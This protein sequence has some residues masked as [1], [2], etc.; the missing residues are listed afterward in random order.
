MTT[1]ERYKDEI[2]L[3]GLYDKDSVYGGM[4]GEALERLV[5]CHLNENHSGFSHYHLVHLFNQLMTTNLL[6]PLQGTDNEWVEVA[7]HDGKPLFQNNRR[8]SVFKS[9]DDIYDIDGGP[10]FE[11]KNG[12]HYTNKHSFLHNIVF[13]YTPSKREVLPE[14]EWIKIERTTKARE[15]N[16]IGINDGPDFKYDLA[17]QEVWMWASIANSDNQ[18]SRNDY[19]DIIKIR[20]F[21]Q[22]HIDY[23]NEGLKFVGITIVDNLPEN[24]KNN[25]T[26]I[27]VDNNEKETK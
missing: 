10:I 25:S 23:I 5:E 7:E 6:T 12:C 24:I 11:D 15:Y 26:D 8:G 14:I 4:V 13:P 22:K 27:L 3:A 9:G 16:T 2:K 18:I 21:E 19:D 1:L 20:G 17:Q